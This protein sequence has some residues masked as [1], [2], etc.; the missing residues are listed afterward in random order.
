MCQQS[1]PWATYLSICID[2]KVTWRTCWDKKM[3]FGQVISNIS[4]TPRSN[5]APYMDSDIL[6]TKTKTLA[7]EK[8]D[9][10]HIWRKIYCLILGEY[11]SC[12]QTICDGLYLLWKTIAVKEV[13]VSS[14]CTVEAKS[15]GVWIC[16]IKH[17]S[18]IRPASLVH[19]GRILVNMP[20]LSSLKEHVCQDS[21]CSQILTAFPNILEWHLIYVWACYYDHA[22]AWMGRKISSANSISCF[23]SSFNRH[24][25]FFFI[26]RKEKMS[27]N[28]EHTGKSLFKF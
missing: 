13:C 19:C 3:F 21:T 10:F 5:H 23:R 8:C 16:K 14:A 27:R 6:K 22:H 9:R 28:D 2:L 26:T 12:R 1:T 11:F 20:L 25:F 4:L 18:V 24:T 7:P 17:M 15:P